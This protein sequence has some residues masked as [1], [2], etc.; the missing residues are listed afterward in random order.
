MA[1]TTKTVNGATVSGGTI[2]LKAGQCRTASVLRLTSS[3]IKQT[4]MG[5]SVITQGLPVDSR[6]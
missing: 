3:G 2:T 6:R 4:A 1:A 5:T